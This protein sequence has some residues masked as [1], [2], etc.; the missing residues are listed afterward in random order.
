MGWVKRTPLGDPGTFCGCPPCGLCYNW[1]EDKP[2]EVPKKVD[3]A[4][5]QQLV[6][7]VVVDG[8]VKMARDLGV[9][10]I[11]KKK[12]REMKKLAKAAHVAKFAT[13]AAIDKVLD[14]ITAETYDKAQ[15]DTLFYSQLNAA[16]AL[17]RRAK[18]IGAPKKN[19]LL[20]QIDIPEPT[21]E[22]ETGNMR[23]APD[24][25]NRV[26]QREM[27]MSDGSTRWMNT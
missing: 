18:K 27:V 2:V 13:N 19:V 6:L 7:P 23:Y 25:N 5:P 21:V 24:S 22:R 14:N 8:L 11:T 9:K 4:Q 12:L 26:V 3:E 1:A 15:A 10:R 20:D 17:R 16:A